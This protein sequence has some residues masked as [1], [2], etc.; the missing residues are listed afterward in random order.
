MVAF[1]IAGLLWLFS[2]VCWEV[3]LMFPVE[4]SGESDAFMTHGILLIAV[5]YALHLICTH[6]TH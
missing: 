3:E 6:P 2:S 5:I 1:G 4:V